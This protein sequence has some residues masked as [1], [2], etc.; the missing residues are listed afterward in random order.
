[1]RRGL[2]PCFKALSD[3]LSNPKDTQDLNLNVVTL[4]IWS[5]RISTAIFCTKNL[6]NPWLAS[7]PSVEPW[8]E[9]EVRA[10]S[11][12]TGWLMAV[13]MTLRFTRRTA[14]TGWKCCPLTLFPTRIIQLH[15][16]ILD[17]WMDWGWF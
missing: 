14:N 10:Q 4:S 2:D 6:F 12:V 8:S 17:T 15:S 7:N 13:C 16:W 11:G 1:V 3:N 9:L 5:F